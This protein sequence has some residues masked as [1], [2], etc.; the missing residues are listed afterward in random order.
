M[1]PA[2]R[3]PASS[4]LYERGKVIDEGFPA[5]EVPARLRAHPD[6]V[7]WLDL[8]DPE[9]PDLQAIQREF[10][11]HPVAVEDAVHDHQRPKL[12]RYPGHVD[13]L[14]RRWDADDGIA[15]RSGVGYLVYGMLDVVVDGQFAAARTL[16]E[17]MDRVEDEMLGRDMG[18]PRAVRRYGFAL[19]R[20]L[21]LLRRAVAPMPALVADLMRGESR[22]AEEHLAPYFRD[23]EDHAR[24]ADETIEHSRDRING[25]LEADLNEQSN[26]LN[27]V[28]R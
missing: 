2:P 12:D 8:Y 11:L 17:A 20:T 16:D 14:L 23:V 27:D 28:T 7:V 1:I 19:R 9:K 10:D 13:L 3:C 25:L 22:L 5:E 4:R 26:A 15:D 6:A 21:A 18:A 24:R